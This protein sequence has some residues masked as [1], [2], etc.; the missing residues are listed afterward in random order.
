M[1]E[2]EKP[3]AEITELTDEVREE[4]ED[5]IASRPHRAPKIM[6][7]GIKPV[8]DALGVTKERMMAGVVPAEVAER[9]QQEPMMGDWW[10]DLSPA[11]REKMLPR[12]NAAVADA[13]VCALRFYYGEYMKH[14]DRSKDNKRLPPRSRGGEKIQ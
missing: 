9:F 13:W 7:E 8:Q 10:M 2:K 4:L 3:K 5:A 11:D 1:S 6:T 12:L 14:R